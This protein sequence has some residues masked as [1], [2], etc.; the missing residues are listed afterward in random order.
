MTALAESQRL[1]TW[2]LNND[3]TSRYRS[4]IS[5]RKG[6]T[7]PPHWRAVFFSRQS[8]SENPFRR[9]IMLA[10]AKRSVIVPYA[11]I[12]GGEQQGSAL[13]GCEP[14]CLPQVGL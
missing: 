11:G 6:T 3:F 9:L 2:F 14:T 1:S 4:P 7:F 8:R 13:G 5:P 12:H 10:H